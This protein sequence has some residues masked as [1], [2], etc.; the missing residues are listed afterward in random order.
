MTAKARG[1][2]E[3]DLFHLILWWASE[4]SV[5]L[6]P[7]RVV[8]FLYLADVHYARAT[9]GQTFTSMPWRFHHFGPWAAESVQVIE[10]A[11]RHPWFQSRSYYSPYKQD[12][13]EAYSCPRGAPR[14]DPRLLPL[15]ARS[16]LKR[17]IETYGADTHALLDYVYFE[18]EPMMAAEPEDPL[19]FSHC[20]PR[21][22][23]PG[24]EMRSPSKKNRKKAK[25]L[26]AALVAANPRPA[27]QEVPAA[28]DA[29]GLEDLEGAEGSQVILGIDEVCD[30]FKES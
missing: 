2:H 21:R 18:T 8:K 16:G 11:R 5:Q 20:E 10:R 15:I 12:E 3:L 26:L 23:V 13:A 28:L 6:T 30:D 29:C 1:D 4:A 7:I 9:G 25:D 22:H 24:I 19:D 27:A 14:G 17:D